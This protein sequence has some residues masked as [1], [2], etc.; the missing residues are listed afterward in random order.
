MVVWPLLDRLGH[1]WGTANPIEVLFRR[2]QRRWQKMAE[3][4]T[5]GEEGDA[6]SVASGSVLPHRPAEIREITA[7]TT[8]KLASPPQ[9]ARA[10]AST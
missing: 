10:T 8:M 7:A 5:R 4:V 3:P 6:G 2:T 1:E 9:S